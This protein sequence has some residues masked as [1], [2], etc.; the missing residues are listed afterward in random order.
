MVVVGY[1]TGGEAEAALRVSKFQSQHRHE[2]KSALEL[3]LNAP[4]GSWGPGGGGDGGGR[5]SD[6]S[7]DD[8]DRSDSDGSDDQ[9]SDDGQKQQQ[10]RRRQRRRKNKG[11]GL[12]KRDNVRGEI[13]SQKKFSSALKAR[14]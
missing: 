3:A 7:D 6:Y 8:H 1:I 10:R 4:A 14:S 2:I 13:E 11:A 9:W 5:A 12:F